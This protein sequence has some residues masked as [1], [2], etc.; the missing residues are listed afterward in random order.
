[1]HPAA[2]IT[3]EILPAYSMV[4]TRIPPIPIISTLFVKSDEVI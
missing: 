4:E 3:R 2:N 1:M